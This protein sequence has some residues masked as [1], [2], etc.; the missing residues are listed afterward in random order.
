MLKALLS[1]IPVCRQTGVIPLA[2]I[3]KL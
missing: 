1:G 2:A 3:K